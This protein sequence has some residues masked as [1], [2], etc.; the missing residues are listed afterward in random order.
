[1]RY[2]WTFLVAL[3]LGGA[4]G[5]AGGIFAYPFLF[6]ADIVA[7]EPLPGSAGGRPLAQGRFIHADPGDRLHWGRGRISL[8]DGLVRLEDDFE[9]GPGPAYHLYL[10]P[11]ETVTP[12][13][14]VAASMYVD[15]GRLRAFKGSQNYRIPA[16]VDPR[17]YPNV[18]VWCEHFGVLISPARLLFEGAV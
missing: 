10:V 7:E 1:M 16:G 4:G 5:F 14:D 15:L 18:V 8:Y 17:Q 9:V 13:T 3:A 11:E 2:F 6:Q 12:A